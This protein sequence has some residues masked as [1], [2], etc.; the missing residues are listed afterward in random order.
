MIDPRNLFAYLW[1]VLSTGGRHGV[2]MWQRLRTA[3]RGLA[4]VAVIAD[5][6]LVAAGR[7]PDVN[8]VLAALDAP[9]GAPDEEPAL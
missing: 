6:R 1:L 4:S 8:E 5:G 7:V 3:A 2:P 9:T